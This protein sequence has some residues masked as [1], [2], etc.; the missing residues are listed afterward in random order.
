MIFF[1]YENGHSNYQLQY[2]V[3]I[4]W[5]FEKLHSTVDFS[6]FYPLESLQRMKQGFTGNG[7]E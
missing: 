5:V 7:D 4:L 2:F 1:R 6:S 3:F